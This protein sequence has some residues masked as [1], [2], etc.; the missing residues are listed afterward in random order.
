MRKFVSSF[1]VWILLVS[2]C[3]GAS[4]AVTAE[5]CQAA[6]QEY[7]TTGST[8]S[9]RV[10]CNEEVANAILG[11]TRQVPTMT[12]A[13]AIVV[14]RQGALQ[15]GTL[16]DYCPPEVVQGPINSPNPVV[17]P[18]IKT[19]VS[20]SAPQRPFAVL[21]DGQ[22][23]EL[24][25]ETIAVRSI[26]SDKLDARSAIKDYA[27][28]SAII[29]ATM[30]G[31]GTMI[32]RSH[33]ATLGVLG[34]GMAATQI[35]SRNKKMTGFEYTFVPGQYSSTHVPPGQVQV[36]VPKAYADFKLVKL[37]SE[38]TLRVIS[39]RKG[40]VSQKG[41]F[42][43]ENSE[44]APLSLVGTT[45][46]DGSESYSINPRV[47]DSFALVGHDSSVTYTLSVL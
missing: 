15:V 4:T 17:D 3:Q 38:R 6:I 42:T 39:S 29:K 2:V 46:S 45:L 31:A 9:I 12:C 43:A 14:D 13:Q 10:G 40:K 7:R 11:T 23:I 21:V 44:E 1:L 37:Q 26:A 22:S 24:L 28:Q 27:V 8:S 20:Q 32:L 33:N 30:A 35:W 41:E 47:G 19:P 25:Q 5:T 34:A 18:T 36:I 16:K